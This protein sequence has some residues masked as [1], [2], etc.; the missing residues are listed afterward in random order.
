MLGRPPLGASPRTVNFNI[1]NI[2]QWN[3]RGVRENWEELG[4]LLRG[5]QPICV[6]PQETMIG[7][8]SH[9]SPKGYSGFYSPHDRAQGHHGGTAIFV[10]TSRGIAFTSFN[11]V[12]PLQVVSVQLHLR[13]TYTVCPLYLPPNSPVDRE[14]FVSLV[15]QLPSPFIILRDFNGRHTL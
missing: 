14:D 5:H 9:P 10:D 11:I 8:S 4:L 2:L 6:C 3:F 12:S 13:R 7:S 1:F 15:Q